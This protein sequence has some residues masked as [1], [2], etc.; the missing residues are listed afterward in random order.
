MPKLATHRRLSN[1]EAMHYAHTPETTLFWAMSPFVLSP[2]KMSASSSNRTHP[3]LRARSKYDS[4]LSSISF[5]V[6]PPMSPH[7][8][9]NRGRP[10][11]AATHSAVD[12][13]PIFGGL[14]DIFYRYVWRSRFFR[15]LPT[16]G[17]PC[18]KIMSPFPLP[19]TRSVSRI[20]YEAWGKFLDRY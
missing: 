2:R 16:P 17:T 12:V 18:S 7:V 15:N 1:N 3:H 14:S 6:A 4:S 11:L 9:G 13:F 20:G 10:V 19:R 8:I 5:G